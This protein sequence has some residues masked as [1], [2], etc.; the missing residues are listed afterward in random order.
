MIAGMCSP[1]V[2]L[3]WPAN[4]NSITFHWTVAQGSGRGL[5]SM[6]S[7]RTT[8]L[9]IYECVLDEKTFSSLQNE[10]LDSSTSDDY[11]NK[12]MAAPVINSS[13]LDM[14]SL[15]FIWLQW[16]SRIF[17]TYFV[18]EVYR[19]FYKVT[20]KINIIIKELLVPLQE[21]G[22]SNPR[23]FTVHLLIKYLLGYEIKL[24]GVICPG[25][26]ESMLSFQGVSETVST[27]QWFHW[28]GACCAIPGQSHVWSV[29]TVTWRQEERMREPEGGEVL[30]VTI[31]VFFHI[32]P[33]ILL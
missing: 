30:Q 13:F 32:L 7:H 21:L 26:K 8:L 22:K 12:L 19:L 27:R 14:K 6:Q 5:H 23:E 9:N 10:L 25:E 16:K 17:Y 28:A 1:W 20:D 2:H 3:W 4:I 24:S 18:F 29:V 31:L 11:S 15:R 33:S